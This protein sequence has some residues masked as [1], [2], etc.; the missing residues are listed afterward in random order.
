MLDDA[1]RRRHPLRGE[2][3]TGWPPLVRPNCNSPIREFPIPIRNSIALCNSI[4]VSVGPRNARR[5][6]RI[7]PGGLN[8]QHKSRSVCGLPNILKPISS[9]DEHWSGK[10]RNRNVRYMPSFVDASWGDTIIICSSLVTGGRI[11]WDRR[12]SRQWAKFHC[13]FQQHAGGFPVI[14]DR[15]TKYLAGVIKRPAAGNIGPLNFTQM[16]NLP[17]IAIPE[18]QSKYSNDSGSGVRPWG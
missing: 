7:S 14:V 18:R 3:P 1:F 12:N 17:S 5:H 16:F 9:I 4:P 11:G 8:D 15:E 6:M 13:V 2:R 10:W